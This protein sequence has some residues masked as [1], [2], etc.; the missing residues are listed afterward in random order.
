MVPAD[1]YEIEPAGRQAVAEAVGAHGALVLVDMLR[2]FLDAGGS[3]RIICRHLQATLPAVRVVTFDID[4]LLD[5]R[6]HRPTMIY[7]DNQWVEYSEPHLAIDLM[8]DHDGKPFLLLSGLE[9]DIYWERFIA[10]TIGLIKELGVSLTVSVQGAPMNV[11]HTRPIGTSVH[12][13]QSHLRSDGFFSGRMEVPSSISSLL[14]Y[15][16][17]SE[18]IDSAGIVVHVPHYL[19]GLEYSPGAVAG[20]ERLSQVTHLALTGPGIEEQAD[21]LAA[22]IAEQVND[23]QDLSA[24]VTALETE[25]DERAAI[26]L[27][28]DLP[29]AEELGREIEDFLAQQAKEE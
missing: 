22:R 26:S 28:R 14:E 27:S 18:G 25:F 2:G 6:S 15:R 7:E 11:P 10:A 13:A 23:D 20:L 5:Y 29:T 21:E 16:L 8:H 12:S 17:G 3:S 4:A 9:P 1:I 19:S 24:L